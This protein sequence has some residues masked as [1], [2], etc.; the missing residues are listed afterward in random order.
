MD[1]NQRPLKLCPDTLLKND[2]YK[3][4]IILPLV[5]D[6]NQQLSE[7]FGIVQQTAFFKKLKGFLKNNMSA[8]LTCY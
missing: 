7:N 2:D 1:W 5:V 3:F 4:W 8:L 6:V